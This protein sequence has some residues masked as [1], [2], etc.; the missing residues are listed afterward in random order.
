MLQVHLAAVSEEDVLP[1]GHVGQAVAAHDVAH[2]AVRLH[3]RPDASPR[4]PRGQRREEPL[5]D[6][7]RECEVEVVPDVRR[8]RP[9]IAEQSRQVRLEPVAAPPLE[10]GRQAPGPV[11]AVDLEAVAEHR[12]ERRPSLAAHRVEHPVAGGAQEQL[13]GLAIVVVDDEP[14]HAEG[15]PLHLHTGR[16]VH[17]EHQSPAPRGDVQAAGGPLGSRRGRPAALSGVEECPRGFDFP[18]LLHPH[19]PVLGDRG[20][21]E[22]RGAV[23]L[24]EQACHLPRERARAD[25]VG[26]DDAEPASAERGRHERPAV[27]PAAAE[28]Q[29]ELEA[30]APRLAR[31]MAEEVEPLGRVVAVVADAVRRVVHRDRVDGLDLGAPQAGVAHEGQLAGDLLGRHRAAEPPPPGHRLGGVGRRLEDTAQGL[32]VRI[33]RRDREARLGRRAS[34]SRRESHAASRGHCAARDVPQ[35]LT[36]RLV[37]GHRPPRAGYPAGLKPCS[38][39][40][41]QGSQQG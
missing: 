31:G 20:Q 11:G 16:L 28:R 41:Q 24:A 13:D 6:E 27:G 14:L 36:P 12:V 40:V 37:V 1:L 38:T 33:G 8:E 3:A 9:G 18:R 15:R 2:R 4:A 17:E 25:Q 26:G 39:G 23:V 10:L 29:V 19:R 21:D 32:D 7:I 5:D 30:K 22:G 35:E 34:R